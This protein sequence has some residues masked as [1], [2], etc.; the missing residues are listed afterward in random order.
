MSNLELWNSVSTTNPS[1]TKKVKLGREFTAID[2]YSQIKEA[3]KIFGPAGVGWGWE[4]KDVQHLSN[5]DIAVLVRLWHSGKHENYIEQWGQNSIFIDRAETK[6]DTDCFKKAE[7]DAITKCL[8]YLGFNADVFEGKFDDNKYVEEMRNKFK[9]DNE[10]PLKGPLQRTALAQQVRNYQSAFMKAESLEEFHQIADD[11]KAI[12]DQA[13][14]EMPELLKESPEQ[15]S[16]TLIQLYTKKKNELELFEQQQRD[17]E[18][19]A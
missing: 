4:T 15:G 8:S 5:G 14:A 7:T 16:P 18:Q 3:T 6:K 11:Y 9:Q 10:I 12:T 13:K 19:R 2:P 1:K 17:M